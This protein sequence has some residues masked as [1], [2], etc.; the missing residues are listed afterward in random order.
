[1]VRTLLEKSVFLRTKAYKIE[2]GTEYIYFIKVLSHP[3]RK[4]TQDKLQGHSDCFYLSF[5][6]KT[7]VSFE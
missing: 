2:N 3:P 5:R 4:Q 7:A 1:M 6:V